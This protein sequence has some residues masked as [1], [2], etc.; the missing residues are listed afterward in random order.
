MKQWLRR[1]LGLTDLET[2]LRL[3]RDE[4]FR[5]RNALV[6][7]LNKLIVSLTDE[8]DPAR[9]KLSDEIGREAIKKMEADDLARHHMLGEV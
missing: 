1:Y 8:L 5:T 2:E 7:P 3:T 6:D 4:L 9:R